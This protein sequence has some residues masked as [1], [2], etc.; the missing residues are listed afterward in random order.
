MVQDLFRQQYVCISILPVVFEEETCVS[1]QSLIE[2]PILGVVVSSRQL[3]RK[4]TM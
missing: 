3:S 1:K 4:S 2:H